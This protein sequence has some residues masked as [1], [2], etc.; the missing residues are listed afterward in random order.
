MAKYNGG[1]LPEGLV[2]AEDEPNL[3]LDGD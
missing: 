2:R 3:F 1:W